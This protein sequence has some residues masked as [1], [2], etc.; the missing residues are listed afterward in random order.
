[1]HISFDQNL[2]K[3]KKKKKKHLENE[4]FRKKYTKFQQSNI[5][6]RHLKALFSSFFFRNFNTAINDIRVRVKRVEKI[7]LFKNGV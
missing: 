6:I 5:G 3:G 2:F 4:T 7:F 1:M